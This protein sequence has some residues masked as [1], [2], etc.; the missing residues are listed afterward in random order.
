MSALN[1]K[2]LKKQL[3]QQAD[4][5]VS[6][7]NDYELTS[8]LVS[9]CAALLRSADKVM[10]AN[11]SEEEV[12]NLFSVYLSIS[13]KVSQFCKANAGKMDEA[14]SK[15][16]ESREEEVKKIQ[17][18][19]Q[20]TDRLR[21]ELADAQRQTIETEKEMKTVQ[22]TCEATQTNLTG[23]EEKIR[24]LNE[25]IKELTK[26]L[27]SKT[28]QAGTFERDIERLTEE[29][30]KADDEYNE[31]SS[32]YEELGRIRKGIE[33]EGYA[34]IASFNDMLADRSSQAEQIMKDFDRI[35]KNLSADLLT[36]QHKIELRRVKS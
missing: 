18:L 15:L 30:R 9:T 29:I 22:K 35:L 19:K 34:D 17:K 7:E 16:T 26:Q 3:E 31:L 1:K 10:P 25:K 4:K 6:E 14:A 28:S 5:L 21:S 27:N 13:R 12:E 36:L 32:Y 20:K 33:E 24:K 23:M 8:S 11:L 2:M